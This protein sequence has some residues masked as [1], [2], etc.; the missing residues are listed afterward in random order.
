M[1]GGGKELV[2]WVSGGR[3]MSEDQGRW[4]VDG[5]SFHFVLVFLIVRLSS[6]PQ[7][8]KVNGLGICRVELPSA[9]AS[10]EGK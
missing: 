9:G 1:E 6:S 2:E 8:R 10:W 4:R 5:F 7:G 3:G